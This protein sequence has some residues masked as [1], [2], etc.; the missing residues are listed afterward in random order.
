MPPHERFVTANDPGSGNGTAQTHRSFAAGTGIAGDTPLGGIPTADDPLAAVILPPREGFGAGRAGALG[1][2]ARRYATTPGF[3]TLV[4]GGEQSGPPFPEVPFRSVKP[5]PWCPGNVNLRFVAAMIGTLRRLRPALIEVHNRPEI[6]LALALLFPRIPVGLLLNNDPVAMRAARSPAAR[7]R[8]L[9][10]LRPV[11]AA[12]DYVRRRFMEGIDPATGQVEILHNCID[13]ATVPPPAE[14]EK[15]ILFAGRVVPDKAPDSFIRACALALPCLPG[16]RAEIIGADGMSATSR[17]TDFVRQTRRQAMEAGVAMIGYRD[18]PLV[19]EAMSRARI[20]V[21]PSRWNEP[22]GLTALEALACGA[23]LIV[24]PRGGLPEVAGDAA[25]YA[26]PDAPE[27]I[28]AAIVALARD[29]VRQATL[30]A[31]G[32]VRARRFDT[33]VA[34]ARLAALRHAALNG[35]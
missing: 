31:V 35:S 16:W 6:A 29:P 30:S 4:I 11:M 22:F 13:L 10:R 21:V 15:L 32:R 33:P 24:A 26:N 12:S 18:H 17:E 25:V 19:L 28:A 7:R 8:L 14:R 2:L 5:A 20:V 9:R 34:A 27:E 1:M 3:R 23:P